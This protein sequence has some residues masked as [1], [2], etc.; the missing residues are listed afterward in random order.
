M[1]I[2]GARRFR[3]VAHIQG[4]PVVQRLCVNSAERSE[5]KRSA[6][7]HTLG[8]WLRG[9]DR[10]QVEALLEVNERLVGDVIERSGLSRLALDADGSVIST[11]LRAEGARRGFNPHRRKARRAITRSRPMRQI[12]VR[13]CGCATGQET[14]TTARRR[15]RFSRY[16]SISSIRRSRSGLCWRYAWMRPFSARTCS[17]PIKVPFYQWLGWRTGS[18]SAADNRKRVD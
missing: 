2:A 15:R 9:F 17:T 12:R 18:F 7:R 13:C 14:F 3:H 1:L 4:D 8:R 16:C 5:L 10:G 11:G 6:T